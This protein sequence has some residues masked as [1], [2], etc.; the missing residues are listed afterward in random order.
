MSIYRGWAMKLADAGPAA[1][2]PPGS[3]YT[4]EYMPA[5]MYSLWLSGAIGARLHANPQTLRVLIEMPQVLMSF[6]LA[7]TLFVMLRRMGY[8]IAQCWIGGMLVAL[9]PALVFDT[10]VWGQTDALVTLLMWLT[11]LMILDEQFELGAA[12]GAAAILAKPHPLLLLPMLTLWACWHAPPWRWLSAA[13]AGAV[14]IVI[15][16]L[17]FQTGRPIG[18]LPHL[19]VS[20]L[21]AARYTS[22]N[23]FNFMALVGGLDQDESGRFL[24]LTYFEIGMAL[25]AAAL[26][27]SWYLLWR[28]RSAEGLM[29]AA[30]VALFGNF[31]FAPRMHERYL[32]PVLIFLV[33]AAVEQ[34][35][36]MALFAA[37]TL[38][39]LFNI[40]D[41]FHAARTA[42]GFAPHDPAAMV[43]A[44][45]NVI[46]F[47]FAIRCALR[48]CAAENQRAEAPARLNPVLK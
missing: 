16:A 1:F 18:W 26:C 41:V 5:S 11:V 39:A 4:G 10:V 45:I 27:F 14:T 40:G 35:Y 36:M 28:R 21:N 20:S 23:A 7:G 32:Y 43:A 13:P 47:G 12:L 46:L 48:F 37:V 34:G 3:A 33:P 29:L 42:K 31:I 19:Y 44:V 30:F 17:P 6:A 8:S 24:R 38:S 25:S 22:L 15:L 2:Y 9:N